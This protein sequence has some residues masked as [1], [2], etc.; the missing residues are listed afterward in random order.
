MPNDKFILKRAS[1]TAMSK[2]CVYKSSKYALP[3]CKCVLCCCA[4]CPC[5]YLPSPKSDQKNSMLVQ[6]YFFMCINKLHVVMCMSDVISMR[7]N[8]VNF[9]M[10]TLIH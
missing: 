10:I 9:G 6:Q 8:S 2:M 3:H 4:K 1:D 5:I 7:R